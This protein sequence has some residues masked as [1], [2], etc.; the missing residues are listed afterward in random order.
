[1]SDFIEARQGA[2]RL[3]KL[4][5]EH[6][7]SIQVHRPDELKQS[8]NGR[9]F[10][11]FQQWLTT[12]L[13]PFIQTLP[14]YPCICNITGGTKL[15]TLALADSAL[16]WQ[17]MD[18]KG[19]DHSLQVF[20]FVGD[21]L[22]LRGKE[23]LAS[24]A[25]LAVAKLNSNR[26]YEV[27]ANSLVQTKPHATQQLA[28]QIWQALSQPQSPAGQALL[29]L[30][31]NKQYGLEAAW[32][33]GEFKPLRS[34]QKLTLSTQEFIGNSTFS[35]EQQRWLEQWQQ[36]APDSISFTPEHITLPSKALKDPFKRWLSGDWLE[37]LAQ[38][39]LLEKLKAKTIAMNLKVNPLEDQKS[40]IGERET[41]IVVHDKGR[42][43]VIEIKTDLA[44]GHK[45]KDLLQQITS[46]GKRLGR[47]RKILMVGPQ[48]QQ[49]IQPNLDGVKQH[50]E[51]YSVLLC[52][53]KAELFAYFN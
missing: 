52:Q 4:L 37:Q 18:Y 35:T 31:G 13:M 27:D 20:H 15:Y 1:M 9:D 24:A 44:P 6:L 2:E 45:V 19:E 10:S 51:A 28:E 23:S 29:E 39:W 21:K 41:D 36:L 25:P 32:L 34:Q 17:Q 14:A 40:S 30:F 33:Y 7:P 46:L 38:T 43:T 12:V 16:G 3:E 8:F 5:S 22:Q 50:C 48:L 42:T 53:S 11:A 26:V 47:T 49:K